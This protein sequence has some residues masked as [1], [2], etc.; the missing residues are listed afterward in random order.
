[1]PTIQDDDPSQGKAHVDLDIDDD[2]QEHV[3]AMPGVSGVL[4]GMLIPRMMLPEML[5]VG[6]SVP[7]TVQMRAAVHLNPAMRAMHA[8]QEMRANPPRAIEVPMDMYSAPYTAPTRRSQVRLDVVPQVQ[9]KDLMVPPQSLSPDTAAPN[10]SIVEWIGNNVL[11]LISGGGDNDMLSESA[12]T[13]DC[14]IMAMLAVVVLAMCMFM[15]CTQQT[16]LI[17]DLMRRL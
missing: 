6:D 17:R 13:A 15:Q 3:A 11:S 4:P 5:P 12:S 9:S 2:G 10:Q 14:A 16:I 8:M 1:M 7:P